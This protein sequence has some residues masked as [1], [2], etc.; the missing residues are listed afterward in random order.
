[1]I[2]SVTWYFKLSQSSATNN[3]PYFPVPRSKPKL[4]TCLIHYSYRRKPPKILFVISIPGR[5]KGKMEPVAAVNILGIEI[6][7]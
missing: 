3:N 2:K 1:M 6:V 4:S 5:R 7:F